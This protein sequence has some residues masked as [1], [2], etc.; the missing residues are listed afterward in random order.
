MSSWLDNLSKLSL[1]IGKDFA[2]TIAAVLAKP[3]N[4][5][6]NVASPLL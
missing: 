6:F 1:N 5:A 3:R 4:N 2:I